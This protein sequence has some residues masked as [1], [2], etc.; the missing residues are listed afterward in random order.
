[1]WDIRS[2]FLQFSRFSSSAYKFKISKRISAWWIWKYLI[3]NSEPNYLF[4]ET[5]VING[6]YKQS[7]YFLKTNQFEINANFVISL[8][9]KIG[10]ATDDKNFWMSRLPLVIIVLWL[11]SCH[12]FWCA[13]RL[14]RWRCAMN[15][16]WLSGPCLF[17]GVD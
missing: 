13:R 15:L 9:L 3:K 2:Q 12:W 5:E 6:H 10:R 1:M 17:K 8:Q 14:L 11:D 7:S 4:R 16:K